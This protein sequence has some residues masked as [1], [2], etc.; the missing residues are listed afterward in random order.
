VASPEIGRAFLFTIQLG[1]KT[2]T[3]NELKNIAGDCKTTSRWASG[4]AKHCES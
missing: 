2:M 1:V 3:I 4:T